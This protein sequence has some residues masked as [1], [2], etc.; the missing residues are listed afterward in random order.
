MPKHV[1]NTE[2]S[3]G[4]LNLDSWLLGVG[5]TIETPR[6]VEEQLRKCHS[7]ANYEIIK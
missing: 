7:A 3:P 2:G 6:I 1:D 5:I 4:S